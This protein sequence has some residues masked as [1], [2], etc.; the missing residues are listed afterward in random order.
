MKELTQ[1]QIDEMQQGA[2]DYAQQISEK[3]D[4]IK[5]DFDLFCE[6]HGICCHLFAMGFYLPIQNDS[7]LAKPL[8]VLG[9]T[10]VASVVQANTLTKAIVNEI[11]A[12]QTPDGLPPA[13]KTKQAPSFYGPT[14]AMA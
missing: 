9:N 11:N 4:V 5:A 12:I 2:I 3:V 6:K 14:G 1:Q 13:K 10:S 7:G 8:A